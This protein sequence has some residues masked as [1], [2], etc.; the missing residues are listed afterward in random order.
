MVASFKRSYSHKPKTDSLDA[1]AIAQRVRF[2]GL[3]PYSKTQMTTAPLQQLTRLRLHLVQTLAAEQSRALSLLF[4]KFSAYKQSNPFSNVFGKAST[5]VLDQFPSEEL[6]AFS[7]EDLA[8]FIVRNGN[9]RHKDPESLVTKA[10]DYPH[11]DQGPHEYLDRFWEENDEGVMEPPESKP[12]RKW[13]VNDEV[14]SKTDPDAALVSVSGGPSMIAHKI[15]VAVSDGPA[16]IVTAVQRFPL[17]C[18]QETLQGIHFVV[19]SHR[20]PGASDGMPRVSQPGT[21]V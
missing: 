3:R 4:L 6:A 11:P 15:H 21:T 19:R 16:R 2:G 10:A 14:G 20:L 18:G 8:S 12:P 5:A 1:S 7:V 17:S 9:N 13:R